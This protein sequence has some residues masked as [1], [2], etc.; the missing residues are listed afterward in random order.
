[1]ALGEVHKYKMQKSKPTLLH[2]VSSYIIMKKMRKIN[3]RAITIGSASYTLDLGIK[4]ER[5]RNKKI[6]KYFL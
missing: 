6:E 1:M 2:P 5:K 4:K 3:I